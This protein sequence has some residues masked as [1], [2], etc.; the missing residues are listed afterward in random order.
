MKRLPLLAKAHRF[1]R[2]NVKPSAPPH[3]I[4]NSGA[5]VVVIMGPTGC[6]KTK[7]SIDLASRFFSPRAEI[8]NADKIQVYRGLDIT[9]NKIPFPDRRDV[10]HH[11]LGEFTP[12]E[13]RPV[14]TAADFRGSGS[15]AIDRI[16]SR[17]GVPF[18]VGG[19]NSFLYAVLAERFDPGVDVFGAPGTEFCTELRYGCCFLWVDVSPAVLNRYLERRVDE[20][21]GMGMV[22]ELENYFRRNGDRSGECVTEMAIGVTEFR[23]YFRFGGGGCEKNDAHYEE[24]VRAIK[25]NTCQLAERQLGKILRLRDAAGWKLNRVEATSSLSAAIAG[26]KTEAAAIWEKQVLQPSVKIVKKF[27]T[28]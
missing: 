25:S 22:E 2:P 17:R 19:S 11:L 13:A 5:K 8:V 15:A 16:V 6:G 4:R 14:F 18:V 10:P 1:L 12:S 21:L 20:M 24:A 9:T 23:D 7:L 26:R 27:L 3:R 28:E